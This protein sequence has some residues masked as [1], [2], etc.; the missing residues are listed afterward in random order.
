VSP[1]IE[2]ET[3]TMMTD[4]RFISGS[5]SA[6]R[7]PSLSSEDADLGRVPGDDAA[8]SEARGSQGLSRGLVGM[9][10]RPGVSGDRSRRPH[11]EPR[12]VPADLRAV[13]VAADVRYAS[14]MVVLGTGAAGRI[15]TSNSR[16]S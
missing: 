9:C 12:H 10:Q 15:G 2:M 3:T 6:S 1:T 4:Q 7:R 16:L 14:M 13:R 5:V 11:A 8:R